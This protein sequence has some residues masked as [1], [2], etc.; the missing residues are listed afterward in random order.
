MQFG[1]AHQRILQAILLAD[2]KFRP[3]QAYKLD[4]SN[5]F[6]QVPAATLGIPKLG[7]LLPADFG[8]DGARLV[9]FPL[10]LPMGWIESPTFFC[11]FTKTACDLAN[12]DLPQNARLPAHPLEQRAGV[13]DFQPNPDQ[14][15]PDRAPWCMWTSS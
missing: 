1:K 2:P 3:V 15:N 9:A 14:P 7:V 12:A 6:D 13:A 5:G 4:I 10:V 11:K 8:Q